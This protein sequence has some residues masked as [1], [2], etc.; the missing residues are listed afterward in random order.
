MALIENGRRVRVIAKI[1]SAPENSISVSR[2]PGDA[3]GGVFL[4]FAGQSSC[5]QESYRVD[6]CYE[7]EED[8]SVVFSKEIEPFLSG[9]F[10]GRSVTTIAYGARGSGKTY[11]IQGSEETPGLAVLAMGEIMKRSELTGSSVSVSVYEV[12]QEDICDLL[13]PGKK[14]VSVLED[15]KGSIKLKGL[16]QVAVNS[17][18]EFQKLYATG[19]RNICKSASKV[20]N[21]LPRRS[22]K[23]LIIHVTS[24]TQSS[25]APLAG[26]MNFLDLAGY[27]D[28]RRES[29]GG[30]R[31]AETN[32]TNKAIYALHKVVRALNGNDIYVPFRESKVTR[33]LQESLKG[34]NKVLIVACL[35][36]FCQDSIYM[37]KIAS[38]TCSVQQFI[39]DSS[40][41]SKSRRR[42]TAFSCKSQLPQSRSV[43]TQKRLSNR[44]HFLQKSSSKASSALTGKKLFN[45]DSQ[46]NQIIEESLTITAESTVEDIIPEKES[47]NVE[48][49]DETK[50]GPKDTENL[51]FNAGCLEELTASPENNLDKENYD[52]SIKEDGSPL[53]SVQLQE[54]S[55]NL[56]NLYYSTPS[57]LCNDESPLLASRTCYPV[58]KNSLAQEYLRFINSASKEELKG[59][60]GI[61][62][63]RASRILAL[64]ETS[65]EPFKQLDDLKNVGLS[66]KQIKKMLAIK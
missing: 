28:G 49:T 11:T 38:E 45:D 5:H 9:V 62:E 61:G 58:T 39:G 47:S 43:S 56:K 59:L 32:R 27:E 1:K 16:S 51:S 33:M 53:L 35:N 22:H 63:K 31:F 10:L 41:K 48:I 18:S 12:H 15:A 7:P 37:A 66:A 34:S 29:N 64:R 52:V 6:C 2:P 19:N 55:N 57:I 65:P 40:M 4:S 8:N 13:N 3:S 50:N 42:S 30:L 46:I 25:K 23:G 24:S 44:M 17:V 26:K 54:L 60:K 14:P 20:G 21:E 36:A